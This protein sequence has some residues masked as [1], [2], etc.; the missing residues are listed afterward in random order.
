[1]REASGNMQPPVVSP[2]P[3]QK[4]SDINTEELDEQIKAI[5]TVSTANHSLS[6][7]NMYLCDCM[8]RRLFLC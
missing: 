1:M 2:G 8:C 7:Y 4:H 6:A 5:M 3:L